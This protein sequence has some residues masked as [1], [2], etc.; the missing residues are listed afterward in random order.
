MGDT[1]ELATLLSWALLPFVISVIYG[2]SHAGNKKI[3][4]VM[5]LFVMGLGVAAFA[6]VRPIVFD[7]L[8]NHYPAEWEVDHWWA[9]AAGLVGYLATTI[10]I[11]IAYVPLYAGAASAPAPADAH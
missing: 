10:V 7:M 11:M 4:W 1:V 9:V 3:A 8:I 2:C 5:D 6:V